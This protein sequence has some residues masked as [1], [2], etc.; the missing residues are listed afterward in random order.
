LSIIVWPTPGESKVYFPFL[1]QQNNRWI[2]EVVQIGPGKDQ[3]TTWSEVREVVN[4]QRWSNIRVTVIE[5]SV[6]KKGAL[7]SKLT[8]YECYIVYQEKLYSTQ[9]RYKFTKQ[10]AIGFI[11]KSTPL[12][13]WQIG[14]LDWS[15][16]K[17]HAHYSSGGFREYQAKGD[18]YQFVKS[19][20]RTYQGGD[21][22]DT[23]YVSNGVGILK[24]I[25]EYKTP[26]GTMQ[27][28]R[29]LT[30]YRMK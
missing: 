5:V 13:I 11:R 18:A 30:K 26:D 20:T 7:Q 10:Q 25:S 6:L 3:R 2:Y 4:I 14:F 9:G 12:M 17:E 15:D 19:F 8:Y 29:E 16:P 28:T 23:F 1:E 22:K 27:I 24:I 21:Y